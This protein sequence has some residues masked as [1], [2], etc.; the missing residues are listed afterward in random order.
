M[1]DGFLTEETERVWSLIEADVREANKDLEG[2]LI[3]DVL[4]EKMKERMRAVLKDYFD[5][6]LIKT[7]ELTN[8]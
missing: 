6:G 3:D 4:I 8:D 7:T 1:T 2:Q 5:R